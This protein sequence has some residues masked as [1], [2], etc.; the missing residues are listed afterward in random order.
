[1]LKDFNGQLAMV[2]RAPNDAV[3]ITWRLVN[4]R[5]FMILFLIVSINLNF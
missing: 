4:F 3:A 5:D 2:P 1:M